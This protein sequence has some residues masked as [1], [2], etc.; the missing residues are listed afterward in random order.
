MTA[1]TPAGGGAEADAGA[2]RGKV[3]DK[4]IETV[5]SGSIAR[6]GGEIGFLRSNRGIGLCLMS[7]TLLTGASIWRSDWAHET[8]RDGFQLG[9]FP[10][11]AIAMMLVSVL[12]MLFDS[13]AR[14]STPGILS[15]SPVDVVLVVVILT[16][17]GGLFLLIPVLGF[18]VVVFLI[19]L[20]GALALGYRPVWIGLATAIGA[21]AGLQALTYLLGVNF[22][23]G[24]LGFLGG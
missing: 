16:A 2:G 8:V 17:L 5:H 12:I 22:P 15:L 6:Q 9:A 1:T 10:L 13:K 20:L 23:L 14:G 3:E 4:S 7:A 18:A 19:V 24:I 11:F 21:A